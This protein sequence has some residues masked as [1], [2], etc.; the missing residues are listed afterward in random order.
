MDGTSA[1]A[2]EKYIYKTLQ[3]GNEF[4]GNMASFLAGG[5]M[6]FF[7]SSSQFLLCIYFSR[8]LFKFE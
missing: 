4:P 8:V 2:I 3:D 1:I 7:N 5:H 6:D